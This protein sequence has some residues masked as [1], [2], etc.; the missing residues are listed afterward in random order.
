MTEESLW[1]K[2]LNHPIQKFDVGISP[3]RVMALTDGVFAIAITLLILSIALPE[4]TFSTANSMVNFFKASSD[5]LVTVIISFVILGEYWI[6]HHHFMKLKKINIIFLWLNIFYL[7]FIMFIPFTTSV[8]CRYEYFTV[9]EVLFSVVITVTSII[10]LLMYWYASKVDLLEVENEKEKKYILKSLS[11]LIYITIIIDLLIYFISSKLTILFLIIPF[12]S[13]AISMRYQKK[14][15]KETIKLYE[16]PSI[17]K[18][19]K[20]DKIIEFMINSKIEDYINQHVKDEEELDEKTEKKLKKEALEDLQKQIN[21]II[22]EG[23]S[24]LE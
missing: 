11:S 1:N 20:K 3:E 9:S 17:L 2:I 8:M 24:N 15:K 22:D 16:K 4:S 7:L 13:V 23:K 6:Q 21:S 19:I 5:Y 14:L 10:S 12:Y 18:H